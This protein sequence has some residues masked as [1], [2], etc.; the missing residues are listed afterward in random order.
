METTSRTLRR[1]KSI[2]LSPE[3]LQKLSSMASERKVS[4][5]RIIEI[6]LDE[7]VKDYKGH[8]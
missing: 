8:K 4:V 1:H 3:T 5:K 2:E 6:C 7:A